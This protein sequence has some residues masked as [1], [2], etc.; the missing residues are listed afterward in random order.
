VSIDHDLELLQELPRGNLAPLATIEARAARYRQRRRRH[1]LSLAAAAIAAVGAL[2]IALLTSVTRDSTTVGATN[3]TIAPTTPVAP[4]GPTLTAGGVS[5][6]LQ[7]IP[8]GWTL[9]PR[10]GVPQ[11]GST[12]D[13]ITLRLETEQPA[14]EINV[15]LAEQPLPSALW[16]ATAQQNADALQIA[17]RSFLGRDDAHIETHHGRLIIK[18]DELTRLPGSEFGQPDQVSILY[19]FALDP[20]HLVEVIGRSDASQP[21]LDI[22]DGLQG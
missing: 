5:V 18:V 20:T 17:A 16:G 12:S 19:A 3:A 4:T 8:E 15:T 7:S 6:T 14:A 9:L 2:S 11:S 10:R 22:L 13:G 21:T 1:Q